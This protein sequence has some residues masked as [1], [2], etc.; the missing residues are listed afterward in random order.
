VAEITIVRDDAD[1]KGRY[2]ATVS[3]I[4][5][6]AE[7]HFSK[8]GPALVI[9]N[10]TDVPASLRGTGVGRALVDR[11]IADARQSG[12]RIVPLCPFVKAQYQRHPEWSDVM[13]G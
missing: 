13:R 6:P 8:A 1:T 12:V 9:A 11:L 5:E 7:L 2:V 4:A 10:H 3:G